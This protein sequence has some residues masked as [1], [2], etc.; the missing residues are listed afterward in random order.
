MK[1]CVFGLVKGYPHYNGYF[2]LIKRNS[3]LKENLLNQ[4]PLDVIIFHEG[5]IKIE[6]QNRMIQ[7]MNY[8]IKFINI[9]PTYF[10]TPQNVTD[11]NL[12]GYK[13]MCRFNSIFI[14]EV[15][16]DYTHA[17][18]MDD[19]SFIESEIDFDIFKEMLD[20][21]V[22]YVGAKKH[23]D[24]HGPTI[25]TLPSFVLKYLED[26]QIQPK[27]GFDNINTE[28]FYNNLYATDLNFW[29]Q[30]NVQHFLKSIDES[31]GIYTHRWG[32]ST[33][34]ALAVKIFAGYENIR[35]FGSFKYR[36]DSHSWNNTMSGEKF[37]LV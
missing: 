4:Y 7:E 11:Y 28:N 26:N 23:V 6:H 32:D 3:L 14:Y 19:D 8:P 27:C 12:I 20:N 15:L 24:P 37:N 33:I 5:N 18:R 1:G 35:T 21:N 34:Q 25:D 36:H 22:V 13:N 16:K 31:F 9:N 10:S 17:L 29:R 2:K 30:N